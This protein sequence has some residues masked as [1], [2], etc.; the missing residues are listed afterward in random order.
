MYDVRAIVICHTLAIESKSKGKSGITSTTST[1][2][3]QRNTMRQSTS[4]RT[5]VRKRDR[6]MNMLVWIKTISTRTMTNKSIV[7][8]NSSI[9]KTRTIKMGSV[10]TSQGNSSFGH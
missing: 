9:Q 2:Q 1:S 5:C 4:N 10:S 7:Y 3:R 8:R 6:N